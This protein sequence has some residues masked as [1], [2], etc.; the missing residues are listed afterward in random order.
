MPREHAR[1]L[2]SIWRPG[3]DFRDRSPAAQRLYFLL[4]SQRELNS[5]GVMPLMVNKWARLSRDTTA[6]DVES[7]LEELVSHGYVVVDNDTEELLVRSFVR[8]D[9]VVK[10]PNV[11]KSA[12]RLARQI[13]SPALRRALAVELV[14]I[15][16]P[17]TLDVAADIDPDGSAPAWSNPSANPS[18]TTS[19][20]T[21]PT[22]ADNP[23]ADPAGW[24]GGRGGGR[25]TSRG[26][27][28]G[29]ARERAQ[30]PPSEDRPSERCAKHAG[31]TDPPPCG[32]CRAARQAAEQ[33]DLEQVRAEADRRA[34]WR[35]AVDACDE[36]DENGKVELPD[37]SMLRHHDPAEVPS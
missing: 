10:S 28:V 27:S 35:L 37:G 15:G 18:A 4:L 19:D 1:I 34:A 24:G 25:G 16:H 5:A 12:M 33:W 14:R 29:E 23:S 2:C 22:T 13:E 17:D 6:A 30:P 31:D 7:A 32:R 26:G 11:L 36:C 8:N 21:S 3:D 9:G 20:N